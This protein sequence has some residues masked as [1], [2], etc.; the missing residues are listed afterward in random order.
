MMF[1]SNLAL[2]DR[3]RL[4]DIWIHA[5]LIK[6]SDEV[7][8]RS[9]VGNYWFLFE[10]HRTD[11]LRLLVVDALTE[12]KSLFDSD[13]NVSSYVEPRSEHQET[14]PTTA[15]QL[16]DSIE[17]GSCNSDNSLH[18]QSHISNVEQVIILTYTI[19][20]NDLTIFKLA[21]RSWS[22]L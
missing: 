13:L 16:F 17:H 21:A 5:A 8:V 7:H 10:R 3:H 14:K 20:P 15:E 1:A 9:L 4:F 18:N 6:C 2:K 11:S 22:G 19:N 12:Q